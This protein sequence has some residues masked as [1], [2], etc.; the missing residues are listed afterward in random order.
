M[1]IALVQLMNNKGC[2]LLRT[3]STIEHILVVAV[4]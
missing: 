3:N 1:I 4:P 2:L